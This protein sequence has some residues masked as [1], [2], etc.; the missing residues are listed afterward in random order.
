MTSNT[1]VTGYIGFKILIMGQI[2]ERSQGKTL[3]HKAGLV[4]DLEPI[5]NMLL[6]LSHVEHT[7]TFKM[8][9][10]NYSVI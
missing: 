2:I 10:N 8:H 3:C 6:L 4:L 1:V 5:Q 7:G 9:F